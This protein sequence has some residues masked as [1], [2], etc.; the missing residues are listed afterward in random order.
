M[1]TNEYSTGDEPDPR[2]LTAHERTIRSLSDR[3]VAAQRPI[4]VLAAIHWPAAVETAFFASGA[5][6]LPP[7]TPDTYAASHLPFN[8]AEKTGE[9]LGIERDIDARLGRHPAGD[10]LRRRC[11]EYGEVVGLLTARGSPEF[12]AISRRLY[13]TASNSVESRAV[14]ALFAALAPGDPTRPENLRKIF[15]APEAVAILADRLRPL[16]PPHIQV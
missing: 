15:A 14:T 12:A 16:I 7:V 4:R 8:P 6:E 9:L 10:L 5:R 2:L 1:M 3:L 13:Q 11:E